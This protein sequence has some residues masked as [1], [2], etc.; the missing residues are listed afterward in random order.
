MLKETN[1][2]F[3]TFI[4]VWMQWIQRKVN[5]TATPSGVIYFARDPLRL[6]VEECQ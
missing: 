5:G 4:E 1:M 2:I 6:Y 3:L